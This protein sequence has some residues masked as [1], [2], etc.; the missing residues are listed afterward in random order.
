MVL[1]STPSRRALLAGV[2]TGLATGLAGCSGSDTSQSPPDNGTL[3]TDYT[4]AITRSP[5]DRPPIT[6]PREKA[7]DAGTTG[8]TSPTPE[9]VPTYVVADESDAESL[10]FAED[11]T[12][13]AAVRRLVAE[14]AYANES[15]FICQRRVR[16]CYRPQLN[17]LTRDDD[18]D[19]NV[20]LCRVIRDAEID[21]ERD[22]Q[23]YT[24]VAVRFPFPA[25]EY[26]GFTVSSGGSCDSVPEHAENESD[27]A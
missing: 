12:N 14:T 21:C 7:D 20:Q 8:D 25:D 23:N 16:E 22:A 17:Y 15:V 5:S 9:L 13:V 27:S 2:G 18:G 3:V 26:G 19:P 4:V 11:A 24:A 1:P 6:A 10:M